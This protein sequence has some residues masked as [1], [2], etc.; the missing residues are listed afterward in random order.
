M[1]AGRHLL[2]ILFL[3]VVTSCV[4]EKTVSLAADPFARRLGPMPEGKGRPKVFVAGI[5][6]D[7]TLV[8]LAPYLSKEVEFP[9][10]RSTV[11]CT[12]DTVARLVE[13]RP[14]AILVVLSKP[15]LAGVNS[16]FLFGAILSTPAYKTTTIGYA[17]RAQRAS[18]PIRWDWT[19]GMVRDV[20][21][22]E[23]A[24]GIIEG[25]VVT[26]VDGCPGNPPK[27][28]PTWSL[29]LRAVQYQPEAVVEVE[30]IR[31]GTGKM[32][33]K[34]KLLPCRAPHLAQADSID[35][36]HMPEITS[37]EV[38]GVKTWRMHFDRW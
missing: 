38:D 28:W 32:R 6:P 34:L 12:R 3:T 25:D 18:F 27:D 13:T 2:P 7:E 37:S 29:F 10:Q 36:T 30:W 9:D 31:P 19:T 8:E 11:N 22:R 17:M 1:S 4:T 33:G 15:E 23:A 24:G 21:D 14:D 5:V 20:F 26:V 35:T 16:T